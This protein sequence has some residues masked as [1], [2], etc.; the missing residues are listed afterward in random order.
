MESSAAIGPVPATTWPR[1][2]ALSE[3]EKL[4]LSAVDAACDLRLTLGASMRP[5][6]SISMGV[7]PIKKASIGDY[8]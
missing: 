1:G 2:S 8:G 3:T 4:L 5:A 6:P 7:N